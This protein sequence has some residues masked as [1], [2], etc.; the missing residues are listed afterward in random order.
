MVNYLF[1]FHIKDNLGYFY[2][3]IKIIIISNLYIIIFL[4]IN[5]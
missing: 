2:T 3:S 5:I 4:F 1:F